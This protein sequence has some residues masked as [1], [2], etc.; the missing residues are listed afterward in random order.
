[1]P[2]PL[3]LDKRV[4]DSGLA[5]LEK[6]LEKTDAKILE[7][8]QSVTYARDMPIR[9]GG[10]IVE[11]IR[12]IA[13]NYAT[14]GD[15]DGES[16]IIGGQ[17][18]DI[19]VIQADLDS[20]AWKTY[21]FAETL[22]IGFFDDMKAQKIGRS[23]QEILDKGIHFNYDKYLDKNVYLGLQ[24]HGGTGLLNNPNAS[25]YSVTIDFATATPDE[26][27]A[28]FNEAQLFTWAASEYNLAGMANHFL[29]AP[30]DFTKLVHR[31]VGVTGD[32]SILTYLMENNIGKDRGRDLVIEPSVW[33]VGAGTNN[34]NRICA[35]AND[36][37]M[38]RMDVTLPLKRWITEASAKDFAYFTPY[39]AQFSEVQFLYMTPVVYVDTLAV[40][41]GS[42]SSI[43]VASAAGTASGDT[44]LA[45][46][47]YTPGAGESY[48]YKV[49]DTIAASMAYGQIPDFTWTAWDGSSDITAATGKKITVIS[50]NAY[51][52]TV[53][54]GSTDVTAHA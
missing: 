1:M 45:L 19:P 12:Q 10:G 23:L 36:E 39:Y 13:V 38:I 7:P 46:T 4:I 27:L 6:E 5:F 34:A 30:E 52:Q 42:M 33:C 37:S 17:T 14:S 28:V 31:K 53:A 35:Y 54:Q 51:G 43:T 2:Q 8:L 40:P 16:S 9:S 50:V 47:G 29:V 49:T 3:I 15:S 44:A 48:L 41:A 11:N 32:K 25:R 24:K 18:N 20:E 26:I 21:I 22:K